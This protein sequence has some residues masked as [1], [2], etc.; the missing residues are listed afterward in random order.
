MKAYDVT[1]QEL[2][3]YVSVIVVIL[4]WISS[5]LNKVEVK[6]GGVTVMKTVDLLDIPRNVYFAL[7]MRTFTG[8]L[9]DIFVFLSYVYTSYS[10]G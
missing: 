1:A 7:S 2:L 4:F 6:E 10:K 5:R 9:S 3:Y 8:F